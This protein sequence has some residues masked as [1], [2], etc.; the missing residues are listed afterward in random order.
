MAG[1]PQSL[2]RR[3]PVCADAEGRCAVAAR[4][5]LNLFRAGVV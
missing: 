2:C 4:S 1:S 5:M 3:R